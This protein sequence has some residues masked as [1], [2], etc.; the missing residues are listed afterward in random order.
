MEG[1]DPC[2][3]Y[4]DRHMNVM[5]KKPVEKK[6]QVLLHFMQSWDMRQWTLS[7]GEN[8]FQ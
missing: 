2:V 8:V 5:N 3:I 6:S 7:P 4:E 1:A